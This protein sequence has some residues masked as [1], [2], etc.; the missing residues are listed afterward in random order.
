[1]LEA[2]T[3]RDPANGEAL[4]KLEELYRKTEQWTLLCDLLEM[5]AQRK[6]DPELA[7]GLRM[8]RASLLLDK[9]KDVESALVVAQGFAS[10]D[11]AAAE[12]LYLRALDS[13]PENAVALAALAELCSRKG[14]FE[15][16][17]KFALEARTRPRTRWRRG[18]C[19]PRRARWFSTISTTR[20]PGGIFS[21]GPWL[22]IQN[23]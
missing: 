1:M 14:E 15:R 20:M 8:E 6:G 22:P 2:L 23:R 3:A 13:E 12:A 4:A 17:A 18:A 11:P 7:R 19:W 21:S 16:A 10:E 9:L 5:R